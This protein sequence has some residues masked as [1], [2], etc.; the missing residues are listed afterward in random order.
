MRLGMLACGV[1]AA[2]PAWQPYAARK[3]SAPEA[4][5]QAQRRR[6]GPLSAKET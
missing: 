1:I 4:V 2:E 3:T 5:P 6:H